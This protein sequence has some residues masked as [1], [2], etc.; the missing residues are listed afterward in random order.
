MRSHLTLLG[1]KSLLVSVTSLVLLPAFAGALLLGPWAPWALERADGLAVSGKSAR[2]IAA[3]ERVA[4]FNFSEEDRAEALYRGAIVA[5]AE[6]HQPEQAVALLSRL[7]EEHP[8]YVRTPEALARMGNLLG[9]DLGAPGPG[10]EAL[11]RAV[12]AAPRHPDA[13][14]WLLEAA[15]FAELAGARQQAWILRERAVQQ[16]PESAP[17]AW[18][19]MARMKLRGGDVAGARALYDRVMSSGYSTTLDVEVATLGLS[20]CLEDLGEHEAAV[21]ELDDE[22]PELS[23]RRERLRVRNEARLR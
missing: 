21:A 7:A 11:Q 9:T 19:A 18:S 15:S 16:F 4:T 1:W 20:F 17:R 13:P 12:E 2:A 10:S 6:G 3:Y 8:D 14:E 22:N 5:A 23:E